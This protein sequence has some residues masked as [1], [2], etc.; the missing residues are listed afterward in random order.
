MHSLRL[1]FFLGQRKNSTGSPLCVCWRVASSH[2]RLAAP[3][4]VDRSATSGA[5]SLDVRK[6]TCR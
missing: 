1:G 3:E 5:A 4:V 2:T 6:M